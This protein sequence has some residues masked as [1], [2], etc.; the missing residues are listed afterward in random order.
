MLSASSPSLDKGSPSARTKEGS[1]RDLKDVGSCL[2]SKRPQLLLKC[3]LQFPVKKLISVTKVETDS[4]YHNRHGD[5]Y[6][7]MEFL[8]YGKLFMPSHHSRRSSVCVHEQVQESWGCLSDFGAPGSLLL[9]PAKG[10]LPWAKRSKLLAIPKP[11]HL[12]YPYS[13]NLS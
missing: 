5:V 12:L 6:Q 13:G 8:N 4:S 9:C 7:V 2:F 10:A 11:C 1:P 3:D